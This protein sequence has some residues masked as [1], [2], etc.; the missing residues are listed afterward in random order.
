M[1]FFSRKLSNDKRHKKEMI[2][3]IF[4]RKLER[5]I[6]FSTRKDYQKM[7]SGQTL[8]V[9]NA[10]LW[11]FL[12]E[13]QKNRFFKRDFKKKFEK[14]WKIFL[15][16]NIKWQNFI[17]K[18]LGGFKQIVFLPKEKRCQFL[19]FE[20]TRLKKQMR[21]R[22]ET[23]KEIEQKQFCKKGWTNEQV[24][25]EQKINKGVFFEEIN[26]RSIRERERERVN[27]HSERQT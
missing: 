9:A 13:I 5:R 6:F 4:L 25:F 14:Q 11:D 27:K 2:K 26:R 12:Y 16:K 10:I 1:R 24:F 21:K 19:L 20:R 8:L 17:K 7:R 3:Y 18:V 15:I 22:C 23:T